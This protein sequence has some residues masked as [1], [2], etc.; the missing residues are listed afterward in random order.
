MNRIYYKLL[1]IQKKMAHVSQRK[2]LIT[3]VI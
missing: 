3:K 1:Y 2:P